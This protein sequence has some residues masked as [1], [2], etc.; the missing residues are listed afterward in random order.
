MKK[1]IAVISM[2]SVILS[3]LAFAVSAEALM[4]PKEIKSMVVFGDS[5]ST[6]YGLEGN[7]YTRS[8]YAN[9]VAQ[10]LGVSQGNG[11]V[12]YAVDGYTS[13]D[14]LRTAVEQID[15]VKDADLILLTCGGNDF[16]R[17][18]MEI[19]VS[20]SGS[21]SDNLIQVAIALLT[22]DSISLRSDLYSEKNEAIIQEAMESYRKNMEKLVSYLKNTSPDARIIFLTQYNPLSGI[23]IGVILDQYTEDVIGRLNAIMTEVVTAGGCEIVDTHA[24]MTKRGVELSNILSSDIHPNAAGHAEMAQLVKAYLGIDTQK[25][26]EMTTTLPSTAVSD[27]VE[28]TEDVVT[29]PAPIVTT[30]EP[31]VTTT[32]PIVTTVQTTVTTTISTT[33]DTSVTSATTEPAVTT[34]VIEVTTAVQVTV[35]DTTVTAQTGGDQTSDATVDFQKKDSSATMTVGAVIL[36]VGILGTCICAVFVIKKK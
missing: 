25:E 4:G 2:L 24:I 35:S 10:A 11:Y 18:A 5:I 23:P 7:I 16:L 13:E 9:L 6:G 33:V 26:E 3:M 21:T 12:N 15:A 27:P 20:A 31:P 29:E 8:S 22:K 14:I 19:A 28:T 32:E 36:V 30:S 1:I 34:E 17:H